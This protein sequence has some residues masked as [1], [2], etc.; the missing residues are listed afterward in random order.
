MTVL[1]HLDTPHTIQHPID[2]LQTPLRHPPDAIETPLRHPPDSH[3]PL[4]RQFP[5]T[6]QAPT[7][8]SSNFRHVG[9]FL[10]LEARCGFFFPPSFFLRWENKVNCYSNQLK[11]SWVCKLE[12]SLTTPNFGHGMGTLYGAWKFKVDLFW[13]L[14]I[15]NK[16]N[17][18]KQKKSIF[19]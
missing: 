16:K 2:T 5:N 15:T 18:K 17:M 9:A 4:S 19:V 8:Q 12:W 7:R 1:I 6:F 11:L 14:Y 3:Q 10:L 13:S